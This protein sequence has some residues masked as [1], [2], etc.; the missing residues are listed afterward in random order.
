MSR[1]TPH[2]ATETC[3]GVGD[4]VILSY[5]HGTRLTALIENTDEVD[6]WIVR[7]LTKDKRGFRKRREVSTY[8]MCW[9]HAVE[10]YDYHPN[11]GL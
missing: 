7:P 8:A 1:Y 2:N 6:R 9:T 3:P 4:V 10:G 5:D 11:A